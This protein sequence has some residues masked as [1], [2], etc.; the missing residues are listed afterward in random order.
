M[1]SRSLGLALFALAASCGGGEAP[2]AVEK[3]PPLALAPQ[4]PH[5][6]L[7]RG[8]PTILITSG[9]H[10][11]AVLNLDFDYATYLKTLRADG[12]NHTRV[13]AGTYREIP[14]SFGITENSL[15]P[16]PGR[17]IC[18]WARSETPGYAHGGAKFDLTKWDGEYFKRLRDFMTKAQ[19][20][21]VVVEMNLWCPNYDEALWKASPLHASNNVNQVGT[22]GKDET[23]T[24]KH[25]DL[26]AVEEATTR[27]IV[28]ELADFDNL[29]FEIC[30]EPYFA[31]VALD[32]QQ[33][34]AEV[35]VDA[36]KDL[37]AKHLISQNIANGRAK[38]TDPN[39]AVSILNFHYCVPPDVVPMNWALDRV[40]G[41]N[42][43]GF[44]GK[45]DVLY[46]TEAW[47]FL[48][49][50]GG[51]Y[52]NLDYSFTASHP[53]GSLLDFKS[54]G[55][56][57]PTLRKQLGIL[58]KFLY[59]FDFVKMTPS[60]SLVRSLSIDGLRARVL[61]EPGR[62]YGYYFHL[63]PGGGSF[64]VRWTGSID[65][66]FTEATTFSV[67]G[68]G[69]VRL[70]VDNRKLADTW[71]EAGVRE[72]SG[73]LTLVAGQKVKV[74]MECRGGRT[75]SLAWS[76]ASQKKQV[77]PKTRLF[78]PDGAAGGLQGDYYEDSDLRTKR[79]TRT[80]AKIE[81]DWAQKGPFPLETRQRSVEVLLDIS[82]GSYTADWVNPK[83]GAI[84]KSQNFSHSGGARSLGSPLFSED[85]ALR[86]KRQ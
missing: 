21:G 43:T 52:N 28:R 39:P 66:P 17:Y 64:S 8:K 44:R 15:A 50:G 59:G 35:I 40:I 19:A 41:E 65:P 30:N 51:L 57:S 6:F 73:T 16:L 71:G 20:A 72:E 79:L 77:I 1:R 56:G 27:Q 13:W 49:A 48:F 26:L 42:E 31:G 83:T 3:V 74:V 5:Y 24:L 22:C 80:D 53:D 60:D 45:E 10:Y 86:I 4:N 37:P 25:A 68:D 12:L 11:G 7:F 14:G 58:K 85:V 76:G 81:F 69:G 33:R 18:P 47:D 29:Y 54:P 55:G 32:W 63:P 36:E 34:I 61:A 67:S 9:E 84:D 78:L 38:V 46:R 2:R 82:S 75:A 23:Y 70:W 62:Q